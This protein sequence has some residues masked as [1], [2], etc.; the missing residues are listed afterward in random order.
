MATT[1]KKELI[2]RIAKEKHIQRSQVRNVVQSF[3]DE[4]VNEM[5]KGNRL[6]FRNFGVF[7]T[8]KRRARIGQNPKTLEQF[9]IPARRG[10][11]F[12]MGLQMEQKLNEQVLIPEEDR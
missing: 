11:K 2:E 8:K 9:P 5:G 7:E 10:V 4:I 6:E 3:L 12:K 1:T